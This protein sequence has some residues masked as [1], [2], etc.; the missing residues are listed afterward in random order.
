MFINQVDGGKT[1]LKVGGKF[2][3]NKCKL[4][5]SAGKRPVK[6]RT[7]PSTWT[8]MDSDLGSLTEGCSVAIVT[9]LHYYQVKDQRQKQ[10]VGT[11]KQICTASVRIILDEYGHI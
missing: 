8:G 4:Y 11:E 9:K 1:D 10:C 3:L 7:Q 6:T 2:H 5:L